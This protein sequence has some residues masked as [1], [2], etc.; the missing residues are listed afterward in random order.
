MVFSIFTYRSPFISPLNFERSVI[1]GNLHG[2]VGEHT[3]IS[4]LVKILK[5]IFAAS[6]T[7]QLF[8][9]LQNF[10]YFTLLFREHMIICTVG[11][12]NEL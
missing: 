5:K 4:R 11:P 7:F 8:S 2:R 3:A 10:E 12:V 9:E 1:G 6:R